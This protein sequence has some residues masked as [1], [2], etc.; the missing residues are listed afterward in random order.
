MADCAR[1]VFFK[2][3]TPTPILQNSFVSKNRAEGGFA[4]KTFNYRF[5]FSKLVSGGKR[6]FFVLDFCL[7]AFGGRKQKGGS[8]AI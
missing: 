3:F 7:S 5:L 6:K 2:K 4:F 1:P 8:R